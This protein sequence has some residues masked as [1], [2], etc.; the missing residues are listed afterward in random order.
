LNDSCVAV[1]MAAPAGCCCCCCCSAPLPPAPACCCCC[2]CPPASAAARAAA[3]RDLRALNFCP[4]D[5]CCLPPPLLPLLLPPAAAGAAA[6]AADGSPFLLREPS[7]CPVSCGGARVRRVWRHVLG[8]GCCVCVGGG[9]CVRACTCAR[10]CG[11][12]GVDA[13]AASTRTST[14]QHDTHPA[15]RP[16]ALLLGL[17]DGAADVDDGAAV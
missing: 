12:C 5:D 10:A 13:G 4:R 15:H 11:V 8:V 16:G 6:A 17:D 14:P 3:S 9:G 7:S 2:C 1:A